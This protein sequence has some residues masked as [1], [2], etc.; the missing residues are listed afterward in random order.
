MKKIKKRR[1]KGTK[2]KMPG[3]NV[4]RLKGISLLFS[5]SLFSLLLCLLLFLFFSLWHDLYF[6]HF[7]IF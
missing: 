4:E 2:R 3:F 5:S 6:T 1:G 7:G